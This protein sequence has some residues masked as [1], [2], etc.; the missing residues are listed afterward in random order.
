LNNR[1]IFIGLIAWFLGIVVPVYH[2]VA[3]HAAIA[4][5]PFNNDILRM[6]WVWEFIPTIEWIYLAMMWMVGF[7][8]VISGVRAG[9]TPREREYRQR[10]PRGFEVTP[11][12]PENVD[13]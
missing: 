3:L 10:G 8:L 7:I 1:R 12:S 6:R 4:G 2:H 5:Q 9:V 13:E 11:S